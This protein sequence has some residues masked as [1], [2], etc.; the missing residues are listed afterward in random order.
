MQHN[1][2]NPVKT[3]APCVPLDG[4]WEKGGMDRGGVI[5][6]LEENWRMGQVCKRNGDFSIQTEVKIR[7]CSRTDKFCPRMTALL[8]MPG[9]NTYADHCFWKHRKLRQKKTEAMARP[10]IQSWQKNKLILLIQ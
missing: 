3:Q 2:S 4:C 7:G 8:E 10:Q 6:V 9:G 1:H 5:E